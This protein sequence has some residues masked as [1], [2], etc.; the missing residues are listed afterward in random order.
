M[1]LQHE[2]QH[3]DIKVII[4]NRLSDGFVAYLTKDGKG[5]GWST[6]IEDVA[7]FHDSVVDRML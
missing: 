3:R 2:G 1:G 5:L 6:H 4:A 7:M